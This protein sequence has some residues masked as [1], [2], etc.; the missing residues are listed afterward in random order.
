[1]DGTNGAGSASLVLT[2]IVLD[3][4]GKHEGNYYIQAQNS[5]G[6]VGESV[7]GDM[8]INHGDI[9]QDAMIATYNGVGTITLEDG[10]IL[11]N[12]GGMS[13]VRLSGGELI[14]QSGSV[15]MDDEDLPART[16]GKTI[17]GAAT[18][19]YG[20]AGAVWMQGGTITME[21]GSKIADIDG[22]AIYN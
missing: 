19:L 12:F 17:T 1:M 13:A 22:R 21:E 6:H 15:I 14:M 2:N 11:K 20:P 16:K 7:F 5:P 10:A 4:D 8:T 18:G 3:D 9:A